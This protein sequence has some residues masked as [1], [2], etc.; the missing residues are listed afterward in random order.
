MKY[1]PLLPAQAA[2]YSNN[3]NNPSVSTPPP[4]PLFLIADM[5]VGK[6]YIIYFHPI[7]PSL[8]ATIILCY[9]LTATLTKI[10]LRHF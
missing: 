6:L 4:W 1:K 3:P 2:H 8:S 9:T 10:P 5:D 7:P